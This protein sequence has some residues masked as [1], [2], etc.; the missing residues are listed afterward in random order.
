MVNEM[1]VPSRVAWL[2]CCAGLTTA[3]PVFVASTGLVVAASRSSFVRL[4]TSG[5]IALVSHLD[6]ER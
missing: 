3:V 1:P 2:A 6:A 4:G 5:K